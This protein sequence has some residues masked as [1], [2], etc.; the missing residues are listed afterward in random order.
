MTGA[1]QAAI[2]MEVA[3][4]DEVTSTLLLDA[5]A[6]KPSVAYAPPILAV[7]VTVN[8]YAVPVTVNPLYY[9]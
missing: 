9:I 3:A 2:V 8:P 5:P 6:F 1:N 4:D 7:P